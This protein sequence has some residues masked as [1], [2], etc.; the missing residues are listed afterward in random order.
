MGARHSVGIV[1]FCYVVFK[2]HSTC[3][4]LRVMGSINMETHIKEVSGRSAKLIIDEF[5][6]FFMLLPV[7]TWISRVL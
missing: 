1:V 4:L 6:V 5:T 7:W 3:V 2:R